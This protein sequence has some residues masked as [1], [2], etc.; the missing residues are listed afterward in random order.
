MTQEMCARCLKEVVRGSD[1][2]P[3]HIVKQIPE[4]HE[5]LPVTWHGDINKRCVYTWNPMV[6]PYIKRCDK[7]AVREVDGEQYCEPHADI[8]EAEARERRLHR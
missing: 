2:R 7:S 3:R 8:A 4:D 5:A 1:G 6:W